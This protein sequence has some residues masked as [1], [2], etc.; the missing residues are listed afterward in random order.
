MT[1]NPTPYPQGFRTILASFNVIL[2]RRGTVWHKW[3]A[4]GPFRA[5]P[6]ACPKG[7]G[8]QAETGRGAPRNLRPADKKILRKDRLNGGIQIS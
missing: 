2:G 1:L 3:K 4:H 6:L 5:P 8:K 7:L